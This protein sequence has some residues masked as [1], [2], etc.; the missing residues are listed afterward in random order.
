[1]PIIVGMPGFLCCPPKTAGENP[2]PRTVSLDLP[3]FFKHPL[4][5]NRLPTSALA[6]KINPG[7]LRRFF[8]GPAIKKDHVM[9]LLTV[10]VEAPELRL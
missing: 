5:L 7:D 1:M 2:G 3:G 6:K 10:G 9:S 8:C 4:R